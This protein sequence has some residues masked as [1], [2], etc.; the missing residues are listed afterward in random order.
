M[1]RAISLTTICLTAMLSSTTHAETQ[2]PSLLRLIPFPKQVQLQPGRFNLDRP[3]VLEIPTETGP[4]LSQLINDEFER[5]GLDKPTTKLRDD[6]HDTLRLAPT[7]GATQTKPVFDSKLRQEDHNLNI[8]PETIT[9]TASA[10]AGLCH[11][12]QTLCQLIRANTTDKHLPCLTILDYPS[13]RWRAFQDDLTRGP[14]TTLNNL[15][16]QVALG[17]GLKMNLFAYY[18]EYQYAFEKHP[19]IGPKDGSLTPQELR[20]LVT[21]AKPY[22]VQI[23]GS[24]QSFAHLNRVLT[25]EKGYDHLRETPNIITPAKEETYQFLND[26]YA[27]VVPLLTLPFFNICC[28]ETQGLGTGPAKDLVAKIG[29]GGVYVQ[30][31]KRLH[32]LLRDNYGKRMMMWGDIILRHQGELS[33]IPTDTI[34]LTWG[35]EPLQ[36]FD[37]RIAPFVQGG[38]EFFVCP[39]VS[40]WNRILPDFNKAVTNIQNFVRDGARFGAL[41][42]LNTAWDDNGE[43]F[44]APNWHG[45]AWG[46]EC[47]WNASATSIEAFN[48]RIGAVLFGEKNDHFGRAI[49]LLAQTHYL[50]LIHI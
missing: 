46:A 8:T 41:G 33:D 5:L 37:H 24:Q 12:T 20:S 32:A 48:R 14:S 1:H 19:S 4:L 18:M 50:S 22:N 39:G 25:P 38:Y 16:R 30:H 9:I 44:N 43:N 27:E 49:A 34:M 7:P 28:D 35:Y 42:V 11:G 21:F 29:E 6:L 3:L 45:Y 47:A 10:T 15:Q 31:M 2:D 17:A 40:C 13:I 26:L 23:L 36:S